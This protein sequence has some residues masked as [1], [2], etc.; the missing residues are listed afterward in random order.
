MGRERSKQ[1][2]ERGRKW[3]KKKRGREQKEADIV[4]RENRGGRGE[5]R[6]R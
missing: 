1:G 4:E 5:K 2:E 3:K 6:E